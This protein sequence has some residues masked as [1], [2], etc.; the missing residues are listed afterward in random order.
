MH[1]IILIHKQ[2]ICQILDQDLLFY[3]ISY[4][5]LRDR[6]DLDIFIGFIKRIDRRRIHMLCQQHKKGSKKASAQYLPAIGIR[7]IIEIKQLIKIRND[8]CF[9]GNRIMI[10]LKLIP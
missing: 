3:V 7:L 8:L 5:L 4:V 1:E 9:N 6:Y 2:I 10:D